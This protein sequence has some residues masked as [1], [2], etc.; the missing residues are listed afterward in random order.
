MEQ[1]IVP[2]E[3]PPW[4]VCKSNTISKIDTNQLKRMMAT[5]FVWLFC[6]DKAGPHRSL[7]LQALLASKITPLDFGEVGCPTS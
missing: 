6:S 1:V 5:C 7:T 4:Y 2:I 3:S